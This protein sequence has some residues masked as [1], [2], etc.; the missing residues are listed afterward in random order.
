MSIVLERAREQRDFLELIKRV[1]GDQNGFYSR[2]LDFK[3]ERI[4][5]FETFKEALKLIGGYNDFDP[6]RVGAALEKVW[7][8]ISS[9]QIARESSPAIYINLAYW[10]NQQIGWLNGN[11]E[12]SA[13]RL[14]DEQK[15]AVKEDLDLV[16]GGVQA[17]EIEYQGA[18]GMTIRV[19]W[20]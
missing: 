1:Y 7:K 2:S 16:L 5:D 19:W 3:S 6:E 4:T 13:F 8:K 10:T 15:A 20:D 11:E 18:Y 14:T 12:E 17:D 9:V